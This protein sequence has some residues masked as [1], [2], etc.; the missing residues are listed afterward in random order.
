MDVSDS[1]ICKYQIIIG[2]CGEER[3]EKDC[4]MG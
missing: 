4:L 2:V 1:F 3:R